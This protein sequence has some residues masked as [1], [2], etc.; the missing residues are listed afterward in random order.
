MVLRFPKLFEEPQECVLVHVGRVLPK[1]IRCELPSIAT[2][3]VTL[4]ALVKDMPF[5][6]AKEQS[7]YCITHHAFA[8]ASEDERVLFFQRYTECPCTLICIEYTISERVL[9]YIFSWWKYCML[10][11]HGVQWSNMA[12]FF[13]AGAM[14]GLL[15]NAGITYRRCVRN[16]LTQCAVYIGGTP[17]TKERV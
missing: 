6:C 17:Y 15:Y 11:V 14:E 5:C 1:Y 8:C 16:P 9:E 12:S 7:L 4:G 10:H 2:S 13:N 3:Y